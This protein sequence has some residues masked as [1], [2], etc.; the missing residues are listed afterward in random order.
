MLSLLSNMTVLQAFSFVPTD[1]ENRQT[2]YERRTSFSPTPEQITS[3]LSSLAIPELSI[4]SAMSTIEEEPKTS[5]EIDRPWYNTPTLLGFF[6]PF[7]GF[8]SNLGKPQYDPQR[9]PPRVRRYNVFSEKEVT[10]LFTELG[11]KE[12]T[13]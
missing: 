10:D 13:S 2:W 1:S 3:R 6:G 12:K 5:L 11:S 8:S 7:P 4:P 9:L